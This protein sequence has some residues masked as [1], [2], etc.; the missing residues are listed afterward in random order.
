[1]VPVPSLSYGGQGRNSSSTTGARDVGTPIC[2]AR[3][4]AHFGFAETY[5]R[6]FSGR[7]AAKR[8][9][10]TTTPPVTVVGETDANTERVGGVISHDA[11][12]RTACGTVRGLLAAVRRVAHS[13]CRVHRIHAGGRAIA[14]PRVCYLTATS[15]SSND[16]VV[17]VTTRFQ[18]AAFDPQHGFPKF[19]P[20]HAARV[21]QELRAK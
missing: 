19:I 1:M 16:V 12:Q 14:T 17:G 4:V 13:I 11:H 7:A 18:R 8:T 15:N 9:S 10:R 5:H 6:A 21:T 20:C 2:P 3:G